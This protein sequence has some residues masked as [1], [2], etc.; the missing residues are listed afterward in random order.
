M[1]S[2]HVHIDFGDNNYRVGELYASADL[3]R[4]VF[5]YDPE[6]ASSGLQISQSHLP[7]GDK[8][9]IAQKNSGFYDLHGVFADSLPDT[10]GRRVQDAEFI[11]IG[12]MEPTALERLA[13]IGKCGIGALH[14]HPA[15]TFPKGDDVVRLADLRKAA[16]R[17]LEGD[18]DDISEQ[19]LK[20]GGSAGGARPKFLVD[21]KENNV[22]ELR[23][24]H[25]KYSDGY[26]P[27]ILKV[28]NTEQGQDQYQRIEYA[29]SQIARNAGLDIPDSYLMTGEKS[30]RAFFAV[31][32]FDIKPDGS[33]LHVHTLSGILNIDYR[34]TNPDSS[35]FLRAIDDITRDH[36]QVIEGYRRIVFNYI[37][38]NKDDHAKNFSF[39]M[40]HKGE[41]SLSPAYDI[42]FSK[43]QNDLHQ[44]R[45]GDK[46]RNAEARDFRSLARD[47]D[48]PKWDKIL[49]QTFSAFEKWPA[50]AKENGV[51]GKYIEM[52]DKKLRENSRR[53]EKGLGR[54]VEL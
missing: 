11:K 13:F 53:I 14:Y 26:V 18:V 44:M 49:D 20:S 16:Q 39:L 36:R 24:T 25:G 33:R 52:I 21:I 4:H 23:Y 7:L 51:P 31:K 50:I 27:V 47:F 35:T 3:G 42:G 32:R 30:D 54:G 10:W 28:P 9:F 17:I 22:R 43:G 6:F 38:S 41:W 40:D 1:S 5:R 37:G 2:I 29:Y 46:F 34:E 48:I 8:T 45:L 12:I 15:R 19:L